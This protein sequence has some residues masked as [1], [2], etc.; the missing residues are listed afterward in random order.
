[1]GTPEPAPTV[2]LVDDDR[3]FLGAMARLLAASGHRVQ[4]FSSTTQFFLDRPPNARGCV[5]A[6]LD[7]PVRDGL[8]LQEELAASSNPLPI[9]FLT[10]HGDI[11]ATVRAMRGGAED[12]L[13]KRAPRAELIKAIDRALARDATS[14]AER[15]ER[16]AV[17]ARFE[18]LSNREREV[19]ALVI[20]GQL[21]KTI[22]AALGI[23]ERTVKL[24]RQAITTKVGVRSVAMLARLA[25]QA[26]MFEAPDPPRPP[27]T[28]PKVQ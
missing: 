24:H 28:F 25:L 13:E 16:A 11:A 20:E 22:A 12:F 7:M 8:A 9:L 23:S 21:N 15:A 27:K 10:G 5:V 26:G 4:T 1:M 6:D 2:Y 19:L 14:Q 17:R 18:A 3:S